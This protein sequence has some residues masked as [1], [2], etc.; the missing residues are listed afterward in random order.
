[1]RKA[2]SMACAVAL[3]A[4]LA[5]PDARCE[6]RAASAGA[7]RRGGVLREIAASG[8]SVLGYLPEMGPGETQAT[9]PAIEKL[10]EYNQ[11]RELVP[12]LAE[13]VTLAKDLKSFTVKLKK[14]I[15]FHDGSALNA[16]AAAWNF[17]LLKDT[18]KLQYAEKLSRIEVV[19]DYT[20][21]LHIAQYSNQ[22]IYGWGWTPL[23]S[24]QAWEKAGGGNVEKAKE[25]ARSHV[26]GTGPFKL[27]EYKRDN[28]LK[29][30]RNENYWQAGK[31]Y[32]DGIEVHYIPEP[33]T[34]SAMMQTKEADMW[35]GAP[36][37]D[38]ADLKKKGFLVTSFGLPRILHFN[39][40]DAD[41]RFQNQKLREAVE[42][43]LDKPA[44]AKALGFGYY[45]PIA[46]AAPPGE[47]G[48]DPGYKGRT[49][50]PARAKQLLAEAGYPNG[51][52]VKL[53]VLT[54][55]P[56]PDEAQAIK[57]YLD[58]V[59]ITVDVDLCDPGRFFESL[60]QKGWPDLALF[61]EGRSANGLVNFQRQFGPEPLTN[62]ASFK[63]PQELIDLAHKSLTL[64]KPSEQ[65]EVTRQLVRM[66][67][68]KALMVPLY[69]APVAIVSRPGV[70]CTWLKIQMVTRYAG[71]EWIDS[72]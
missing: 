39:T 32:L 40:K 38:V 18:N 10:M 52:K 23:F 70:H 57:R 48:Y 65:E 50:D 46:A 47:W 34:A 42:Y 25:W 19:D 33:V 1:M 28:Y 61:V 11:E 66:I 35:Y 51:L 8:P 17:Q 15:K 45:T 54:A 67:A 21:K 63:R 30:V 29:W 69:L 2:W 64:V 14:G 49:Y 7:P 62:L 6:E 12:F 20:L 36:M 22:L 13:S 31:P 24:K 56:W 41:S 60:W 4:A 68:D 9:M 71:D 44:I 16:E 53:M 27:A 58:E 72:Q 3:L 37:K 55:P 26:V 59:G 5:L 43:A